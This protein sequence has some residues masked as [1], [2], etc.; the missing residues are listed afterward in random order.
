[1]IRGECRACS[2]MS[3]GHA[4]DGGTDASTDEPKNEYCTRRAD[5][6][7]DGAYISLRQ[8]EEDR[9]TGAPLE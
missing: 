8:L 2:R 1:M 3:V 5:G 6:L 4:R 9:K 7:Q